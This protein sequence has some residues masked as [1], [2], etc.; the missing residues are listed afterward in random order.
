LHAHAGPAR[1]YQVNGDATIGPELAV[2]P[3]A[4]GTGTFEFTGDRDQDLVVHQLLRRPGRE[5][6]GEARGARFDDR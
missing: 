6:G 5:H 4:D 1:P 3:G 2:Q